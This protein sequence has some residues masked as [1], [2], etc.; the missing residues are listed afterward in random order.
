LKFA[1]FEM[2][3]QDKKEFERTINRYIRQIDKT[4]AYLSQ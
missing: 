3:E 2:T 4:I 1:A